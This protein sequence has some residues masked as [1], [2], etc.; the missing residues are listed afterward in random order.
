MAFDPYTQ[1]PAFG[2]V[3]AGGNVL[4]SAEPPVD[5]YTGQ[6]GDMEYRM[7][8]R[9]VTATS[10]DQLPTKEG[11]GRERAAAV[12]RVRDAVTGA[13]TD[14]HV[15]TPEYQ[16]KMNTAA[17]WGWDFPGRFN[18]HILNPALNTAAA[19]PAAI[20][21]GV[22]A[23][24]E[25]L[26]RASGAP[27]L[28]RDINAAVASLSPVMA[29]MAPVL[30]RAMVPRLEKPVGAPSDR[31][32]S[33]APGGPLNREA[34]EEALRRRA[35]RNDTMSG[36][37]PTPG[38][39]GPAS[40]ATLPYTVRSTALGVPDAEV[41][42]P[43][44]ESLPPPPGYV[45]PSNATGIARD[46]YAVGKAHYD[47]AD[48]YGGRV[49]A[50][51]NDA[52]LDNKISGIRTQ[53]PE[54][55]RFD[56]TDAVDASIVDLNNALRGQELSLRGTQEIDKKI[57]DRIEV[58][59]RAGKKD[60]A[61]RLLEMQHALRD[62]VESVGEG[63][64]VGGPAGFAAL[65][66]ARR[67]WSVAVRMQDIERMI[68]KAEGTLNPQQSMR[69]QVNSYVNNPKMTRG[70][71]PKDLDALKRTSRTGN[72]VEILRT[73][74]S[75]LAP[76]G[77]YA[78]AGPLGAAAAVTETLLANQARDALSS[79]YRRRLEGVSRQLSTHLP[80][81]PGSEYG[82][83]AVPPGVLQRASPVGGTQAGLLG[84]MVLGTDPGELRRQAEERA[85]LEEQLRLRGIQ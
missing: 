1:A 11:E 21:A 33:T 79:A 61:S 81:M 13:W 49:S 46:A 30:P 69:T 39:E 22:G 65:K 73:L 84:R 12:K 57:G 59:L 38:P 4:D 6:R 60:E 16:E 72:G 40:P 10:Y 82:P 8:P 9:P 36:G 74:S 68:E 77:G 63:E 44:A 28:G 18:R 75:R 25:E 83:P 2:H 24:A 64:T 26:S 31:P 37:T 41:R 62:H 55:R 70:W 7:T 56:P 14:A 48:H 45:P 80:G 85:R 76:I 17:P 32:V 54:A 71:D 52:F 67:A 29:A 35:E 50:K 43:I 53:T 19:I 5:P 20:G 15:M 27:G 78:V 51:A 42:A 34:L 58:A 47:L 3:G 23:T 66:D